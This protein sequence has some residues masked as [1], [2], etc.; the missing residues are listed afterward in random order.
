[1]DNAMARRV[2]MGTAEV[3]KKPTPPRKRLAGKESNI[4]GF[5]GKHLNTFEQPGR[6]ND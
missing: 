5:K 2:M 4:M 6:E 1:M 3:S